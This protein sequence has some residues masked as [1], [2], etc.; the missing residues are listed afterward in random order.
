MKFNIK[1][2][3]LVILCT[4]FV[5]TSSINAGNF[6]RKNSATTGFV[7]GVTANAVVK[8]LQFSN[9]NLSNSIKIPIFL[10]INALL[11]YGLSSNLKDEGGDF[12]TENIALS[13]GFWIAGVSSIELANALLVRK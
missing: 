4:S 13:I 10:A 1:T 11:T 9:K 3:F 2:L 12:D 8:A 6:N 5:A 7:V